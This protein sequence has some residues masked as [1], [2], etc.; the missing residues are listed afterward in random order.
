MKQVELDILQ[1]DITYEHIENLTYSELETK[2]YR[3]L[4]EEF[5]ENPE[6]K[7]VTITLIEPIKEVIL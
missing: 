7:T 3:E 5:Y 1:R 2:T 6:P 4:Q